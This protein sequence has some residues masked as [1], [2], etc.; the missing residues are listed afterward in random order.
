M[1][2]PKANQYQ[3]CGKLLG[4]RE[5]PGSK[6]IPTIPKSHSQNVETTRE[7]KTIVHYK[8]VRRARTNNDNN[9]DNDS[10]VDVSVTATSQRERVPETV[11]VTLYQCSKG[12]QRAHCIFA[13]AG[14]PRMRQ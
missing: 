10:R 14:G 9:H 8:S 5:Q 11:Q 6:T 13:I 7:G 2:R 3:N 12:S 1:F 4:V